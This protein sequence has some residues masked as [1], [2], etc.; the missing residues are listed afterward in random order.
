M[1]DRAL[2]R[3]W[4]VGTACAAVII[5]LVYASITNGSFDISVKDVAAAL[6]RLDPQPDHDL[7]IFE[8]RLPRIVLGALVGVALGVSG[9]AL[10]GVTRNGLADPGILGIH[11][12]AGTAIVLY[13]LVFHGRIKG[14]G[15]LPAMTMPLFGLAGG[16]LAV[17]LLF[18]FSRHRGGFDPRRLVLVGIA[19]GSGFGAMTTYLS[20][21]MNPNDFEMAVVWLAGSI[22]SANWT[23]VA[24]IAPWVAVL[25]P[26]IWSKSAALDVLQLGDE[27]AA[28]L[29]AE[30]ARHKR[31]LLLCC[32]GLTGASVAVAGSIGFIGLLS[33]HIARRLTGLRHKY[34][35]PASGLIG[36]ALMIGSDFIGRIAFAPVQL[37][38]GVV[39]SLIGVPY[40]VYL[41]VRTRRG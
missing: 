14:V 41:L 9:A 20:L 8:F 17:L 27:S 33:P 10:Q 3:F 4:L 35:L 19:I 22:H 15:L 28:G 31:A 40:F 21:K 5:C 2:A 1:A 23:F 29:G 36:C 16:L 25:A 39:I 6:L 26:L 18:Y 11:A 32:V 37:P 7:V 34:A 24:A 12:A 38:A 30:V 13:M